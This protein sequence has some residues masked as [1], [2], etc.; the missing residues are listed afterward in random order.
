MADAGKLLART[1]WTIKQDWLDDLLSRAESV[2]VDAMQAGL[3]ATVHKVMLD[4]GSYVLKVWDKH[5]KPDIAYQYRLL[6]ALSE[7]GIPVSKPL[8]FGLT[9][10]GNGA[11][12]TSDDGA[13]LTKLDKRAHASIAGLMADVHRFPYDPAGDLRVDK[14]DFV[15][16]FYPGIA[17]QQDLRQALLEWIG[18]VGIRQDAV[19]HGDLHL[20]NLVEA[21]GRYTAI[22]WTNGQLGDPRYDLMWMVVITRLYVSDRHADGLLQAYSALIAYPEAELR[23]FEAIAFARWLLL[24]RQGALPVDA[25]TKKRIAAMISNNPLLTNKNLFPVR[26]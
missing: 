2:T 6:L 3:E 20:G 19:I 23:A 25:K 9:E 11:L 13:P 17:E 4:G 8:G 1:S 5:S 24:H 14:H 12:L 21:D 15:S 16:Y 18:E 26:A 22:D 7:H 10:D